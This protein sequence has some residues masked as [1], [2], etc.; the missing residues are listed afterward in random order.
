MSKLN[1]CKDEIDVSDVWKIE[2]GG[3]NIDE[4]ECGIVKLNDLK[5]IREFDG[6]ATQ[7]IDEKLNDLHTMVDR[8]KQDNIGGKKSKKTVK[9]SKKVKKI[10]RKS[11]K[12]ENPIVKRIKN[13]IYY[14]Y[15]YYS[16]EYK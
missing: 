6:D 11:R 14:L 1:L 7:E 12:T 16:Y 13:K 8:L 5:N 4:L 9:K 15:K 2:I 10:Q 3:K